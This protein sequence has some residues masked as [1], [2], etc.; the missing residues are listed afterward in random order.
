VETRA[1]RHEQDDNAEHGDGICPHQPRVELRTSPAT[2]TAKSQAQALVWAL[3]AWAAA[4][5]RGDSAFAA[6]EDRHDDQRQG[7]EAIPMGL[8]SGSS[9]VARRWRRGAEAAA[10]GSWRR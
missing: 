4:V 1:L 3:S 2:T 9:R 6:G 10:T 8:A 5:G 7:G